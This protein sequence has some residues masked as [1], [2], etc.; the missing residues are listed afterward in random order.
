VDVVGSRLWELHLKRSA[1]L[2]PAPDLKARAQQVA[3]RATGLLE[4]L[5]LL[6]VDDVSKTALLRSDRPGQW[7]DGLYYYEVL[8]Q[9]DGTTTLRRYQAPGQELPRRR[10]LAFSL[11]HEALAKLAQDLVA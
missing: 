1:P 7:G 10:Q 4:S 5:R 6:E 2:N 3:A 8:L 11:T 9:E